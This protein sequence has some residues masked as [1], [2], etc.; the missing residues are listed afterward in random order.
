MHIY[1]TY[2]MSYMYIYIY[3]HTINSSIS[4]ICVSIISSIIDI[5]ISSSIRSIPTGQQVRARTERSAS[6][7]LIGYRVFS[8]VDRELK[9]DC[10]GYKFTNSYGRGA[11]MGCT[12]LPL[13]RLQGVLGTMYS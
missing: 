8:E 13:K 12:I 6:F 3:I 11:V 2:C 5:T 4:I 7:L 10:G 1:N 9:G